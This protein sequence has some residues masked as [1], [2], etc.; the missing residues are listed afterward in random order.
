VRIVTI[1]LPVFSW[2]QQHGKKP[3]SDDA[4]HKLRAWLGG[5][6][7]RRGN[8]IR[9]SRSVAALQVRSRLRLADALE[10]T[11]IGRNLPSK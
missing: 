11:L 8:A 1:V 2:L 4:D 7:G 3:A 6:A 10:H 9:S 5:S